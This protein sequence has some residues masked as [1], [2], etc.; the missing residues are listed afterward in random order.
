MLKEDLVRE[1]D[2]SITD[3]HHVDSPDVC[4]AVSKINGWSGTDFSSRNLTP[5][6]ARAA[7]NAFVLNHSRKM[8]CDRSVCMECGCSGS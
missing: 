6:L 3:D 2:G 1:H 5:D 7:F 4:L 8:F